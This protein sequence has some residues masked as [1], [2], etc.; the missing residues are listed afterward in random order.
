[1]AV[2]DRTANGIVDR[3]AGFALEFGDEG[4]V[5]GVAEASAIGPEGIGEVFAFGGEHTGPGVAG[6]AAKGTGIDEGD[7]VA[8]LA[9]SPGE[10]SADES[11][12]DD[13][14][15]HSSSIAGPGAGVAEIE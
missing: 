12:A 8:A 15:V 6:F 10:G 14:A 5:E 7:L 13:Q 11:G 4:G 1:M 2:F 3:A 9:Q